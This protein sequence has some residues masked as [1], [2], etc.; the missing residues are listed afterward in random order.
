MRPNRV[1]VIVVAGV[2][3]LAVVAAVVAAGRSQP[4]FDPS[5][6]EGAVQGYLRAVLEDDEEAAAGYLAADSD[7]GVA[8]FES[9]AVDLSAR[10]VLRETTVSGEEA[11]VEVEVTY[12]GGGGPFDTYEWSEDQA[13]RLVREEGNWVL[14]GRPW[15]LYFCEK[16]Q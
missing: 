15:P 11:T 6:P 5:T 10:V 13:F 8:D 12:T 2:A 16:G 3:L 4:T 14:E 7:C 1:L 9:A